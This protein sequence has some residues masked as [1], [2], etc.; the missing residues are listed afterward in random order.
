MIDISGDKMKLLLDFP[1]IGE[2]HYAQAIPSDI[3][4]KNSRRFIRLK[5][6]LIPMESKLRK[7][8]G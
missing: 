1:T 4:M 8:H 7:M 3:L 6:I 2:P 5:R